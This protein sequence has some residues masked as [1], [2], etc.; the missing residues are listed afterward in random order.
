MSRNNCSLY[1][2]YEMQTLQHDLA[3]S[4]SFEGSVEDVRDLVNRNG[5]LEV[6]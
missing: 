5:H 3:V 6:E 1:E 2:L 4:T